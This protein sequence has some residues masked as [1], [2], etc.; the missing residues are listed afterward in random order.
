MLSVTPGKAQTVPTHPG[1]TPDAVYH[2]RV[3]AA[4]VLLA[5]SH[6]HNASR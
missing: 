4:I 6:H 2:P 3:F 5:S 1:S